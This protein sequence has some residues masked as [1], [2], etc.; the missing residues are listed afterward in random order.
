MDIMWAMDSLDSVKAFIHTLPDRRDQADCLGLLE[1]AVMESHEE[2]GDLDEYADQ[3][4]SIIARAR[5]GS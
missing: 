1:I 3:A 5:A 2:A 4:I